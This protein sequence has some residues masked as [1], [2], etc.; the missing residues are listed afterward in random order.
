MAVTVR[1][2]PVWRSSTGGA[3]QVEASPGDMSQVL[4]GLVEQFPAL[5]SQ[6]LDDQGQVRA[7][8]NLFVNG[9]HVRFRGGLSSAL[10]DGDEVY[11]VPMIT[12]GSRC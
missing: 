2:P 11:I 12:G 10:R 4:A 1:I 5:R 9:E 3:G 6:L 8:V 7:A